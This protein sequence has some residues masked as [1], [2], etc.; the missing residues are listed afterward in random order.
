MIHQ[1]L[2]SGESG[3]SCGTCGKVMAARK[4]MRRHCE[5]HVDYSHECQY[6]NKTFKTSNAF[7]QHHNIYHKQ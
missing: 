1:R 5:T 7:R 6:C 2:E 3:W 4:D